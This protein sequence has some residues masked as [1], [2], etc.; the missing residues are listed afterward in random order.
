MIRWNI[1]L[2][3][4]WPKAVKCYMQ[5]YKKKPITDIFQKIWPQVQSRDVEKYILTQQT[6]Q[7][8][9]DVGFRLIWRRDVYNV[10]LTLSI[11]TLIWTTL[12]K[13]VIFNVGLYKVKP[14]RINVVN[15]TTKKWKNKL[16]VK[17]IIILLIFNIII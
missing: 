5:I 9:F 8:C 17:N 10:K 1:L 4:Q 11:S 3:H 14:R 7:R 12:D 2:L 6:F 13:V 15:M 16:R